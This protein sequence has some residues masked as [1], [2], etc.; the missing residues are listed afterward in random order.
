M[1]RGKRQQ[2][3]GAAGK[4]QKLSDV[5]SG[6]RLNTPKQPTGASSTKLTKNQRKAQRKKDA[7][8]KKGSRVRVPDP[9]Q[10][11]AQLHAQ[12]DGSDDNRQTQNRHKAQKHTQKHTQNNAQNK[13]HNNLVPGKKAAQAKQA[14][15][16]AKA[17]FG[18]GRCVLTAV[19]LE[20]WEMGVALTGEDKVWRAHC[21]LLA[22]LTRDTCSPHRGCRCAVECTHCRIG[23]L[24]SVC[25]RSFGNICMCA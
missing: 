21:V 25:R 7:K 8:L 10:R 4:F 3:D 24:T 2:H 11:E 20:W 19:D 16:H 13:A 14:L 5:G 23:Q 18:P 17:Y 6:P 22:S 9:I 1:G 12:K 15:Q